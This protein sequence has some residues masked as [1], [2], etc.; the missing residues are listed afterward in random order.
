MRTVKIVVELEI[1]YEEYDS[2]K[3]NRR[4]EKSM[5]RWVRDTVKESLNFV[6]FYPEKAENGSWIEDCSKKV[7]SKTT[8][9]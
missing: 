8:M 1:P 4:A 3:T 9:K 2:E 5:F 6:P 7:K